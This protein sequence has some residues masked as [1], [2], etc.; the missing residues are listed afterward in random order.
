MQALGNRWYKENWVS[1]EELI[2][3]VC[4]GVGKMLEITES[5]PSGQ[6]KGAT[7]QSSEVVWKKATQEGVVTFSQE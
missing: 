4:K 7:E 1:K 6:G 3:P 5:E 2:V